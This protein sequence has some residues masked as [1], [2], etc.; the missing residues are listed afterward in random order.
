MSILDAR[1]YSDMKQLTFM[2]FKSWNKCFNIRFITV[3][4]PPMLN[5]TVERNSFYYQTRICFQRTEHSSMS[6]WRNRYYSSIVDLTKS[7]YFSL[8]CHNNMISQL[9]EAFSCPLLSTI[10]KCAVSSM[11]HMLK[12]NDYMRL[13]VT[14]YLII[15]DFMTLYSTTCFTSSHDYKLN[16]HTWF[17]SIQ[18][19]SIQF[20]ASL[21][22]KSLFLLY[23]AKWPRI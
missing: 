3:C 22:L 15:N 23:Q 12:Y 17:N 14:I 16:Y 10:S 4:K 7:L 21:F 18:D 6:T 13:N 8:N 2:C 5:Y 1:F 9:A 19:D 20:I 11:L